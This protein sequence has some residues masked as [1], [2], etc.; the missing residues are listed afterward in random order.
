MAS[1]LSS[2]HKE[3][4]ISSR[5]LQDF[6]NYINTAFVIGTF[7]NLKDFMLGAR[8]PIL[9]MSSF[10]IFVL[11]DKSKCYSYPFIIYNKFCSLIIVLG[12]FFHLN[13]N[14]TLR[15]LIYSPSF[16]KL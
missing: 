8:Y 1:S 9:L 16:G 5:F 11:Y 4:S 6:P 3:I 2:L 14:F 12:S 13:K 10:E 7:D 15:C